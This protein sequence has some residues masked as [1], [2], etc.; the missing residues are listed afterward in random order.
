MYSP[1]QI[2]NAKNM[3]ELHEICKANE[4]TEEQAIAFIKWW[5]ESPGYKTIAEHLPMIRKIRDRVK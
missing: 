4:V 3:F 2:N 5:Q 1:H